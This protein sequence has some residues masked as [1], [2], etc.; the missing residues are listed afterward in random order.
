MFATGFCLD[1]ESTTKNEPQRTELFLSDLA[2]EMESWVIGGMTYPAKEIGKA[3]NTAVTFDPNGQSISVYKKIHP[4]P[5]LA[6]DKVHLEGRTIENLS[7][8]SFNV[9]PAI[10]YDL[11][12]P[13]LFRSALHSGTIFCCV[14]LLAKE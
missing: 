6:E 12:F 14:R 1:P 8:G 7:I 3:Y 10:C 2:R 9:T 13:E 11:R 5:I 4:I